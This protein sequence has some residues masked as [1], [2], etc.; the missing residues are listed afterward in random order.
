MVLLVPH[1]NTK[2][3]RPILAKSGTKLKAMIL[4]SLN[5]LSVRTYRPARRTSM[6]ATAKPVHH[7]ETSSV[8]WFCREFR[9]GG[10][11]ESKVRGTSMTDGY[12]A[13]QPPKRGERRNAIWILSY[14]AIASR[15]NCDCEKGVN[16][17]VDVGVDQSLLTPCRG[18]EVVQGDCSAQR[19]I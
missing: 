11:L 9:G 12:N 5:S 6:I 1:S 13:H 17:A 14:E 18:R 7:H 4:S 8:G 15:I 10:G 3:T 19:T 2:C 16:K